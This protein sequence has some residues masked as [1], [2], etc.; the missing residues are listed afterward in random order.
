MATQSFSDQM[1]NQVLLTRPPQ[2]IVSLVPSQTELLFDLGLDQTVLG[3]TKFCIH[4]PDWLTRK[5]IV[6][7]TKKFHFD[8]IDKLDP[9]LI[10]GNKEENYQEGIETLR[11]KY[12]VWMSDIHTL[13]SAL[14][15]ITSIGQLV[16]KQ[17]TAIEISQ[18]ILKSFNNVKRFEGE[19]V[20]YLIWKKP[21]MAV[22]SNTFIHSLLTMLGLR[23]TLGLKTR[24]P[25]LTQQEIRELNADFIFLS[26]E[27]FPFDESHIDEI[28]RISPKS[29]ILLVDGEMFSWYGSRLLQ[30]SDY[31][32]TL[33]LG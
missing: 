10:I 12:T 15:M 27:P 28:K 21:W 8:I 11:E 22:G 4:P 7:G 31:F 32:N 23:N 9:D 18:R 30:S 24:Y 13:E 16:G 26:S 17:E 20:L 33:K 14:S 19:S 29:K 1:G 25:E 3:I 5:V 2:R 6:G